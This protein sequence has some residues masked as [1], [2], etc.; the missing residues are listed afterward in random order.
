MEEQRLIRNV[1]ICA[2]STEEVRSHRQ[3]VV[4]HCHGKAQCRNI[5]H[6]QGI[7]L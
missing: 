4:Q 5:K 7:V 3:G 6:R 1:R 2:Y